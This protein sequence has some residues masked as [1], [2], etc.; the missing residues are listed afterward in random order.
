M[1]DVN[2]FGQ[3]RGLARTYFSTSQLDVQPMLADGGEQLVSQALPERTELVKLGK[4]FGAAIPTASA[5]TYVNAWPTTRAE[6]VLLNGESA[7]GPSYVV[8]RAWM[9]SIT[10][11]ATGPVALLGQ[12]IPATAATQGATGPATADN[13]AIKRHQMSGRTNNTITSNARLVL[14]NVQF[15]VADQWFL[16]GQTPGLAATAG[17]AVLAQGVEAQVLGRIIIPPQAAFCLAGIASIGAGT[18]IAG[19]EWHEVQLNLG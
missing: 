9:A 11:G 2:I 1:T 17:G 14:A 10:A 4:S 7:G 16:L 19:L 8:D 15:A 5:F 13:T 18:A 12:I 6:L 3:I